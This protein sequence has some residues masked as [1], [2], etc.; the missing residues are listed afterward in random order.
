MTK[1]EIKA[2]LVTASITV[3]VLGVMGAAAFFALS[4]ISKAIDISLDSDEDDW[5]I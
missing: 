5:F 2:K 1:D 3:G 4:M